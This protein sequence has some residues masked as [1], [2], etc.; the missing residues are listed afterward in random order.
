MFW[1]LMMCL[2]VVTLILKHP[3]IFGVDAAKTAAQAPLLVQIMKEAL[4]ENGLGLLGLSVGFGAV[5]LVSNEAPA[6]R[7]FRCVVV[8]IATLI[9]IA[10]MPVQDQLTMI[11]GASESAGSLLWT[12]VLTVAGLLAAWL[13]IRQARRRMA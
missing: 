4:W 7:F 2:L 11:G 6:S 5:T 12:V 13:G 8:G 3:E 1:F 10:L 9:C